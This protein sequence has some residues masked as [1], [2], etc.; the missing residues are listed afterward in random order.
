LLKV[1]CLQGNQE[2]YNA[3]FSV[4]GIT[5]LQFFRHLTQIAV[6]LTLNAKYF[7]IASSLIIVPYL[8]PTQAQYSTVHGLYESLEYTLCKGWVP[9]TVLAIVG[10]TGSAV[11]RLFCGW[12]CP[13]GMVQDFLSYLPFSKTRPDPAITKYLKG[14][15]WAILGV[16]LFCA[17]VVGQR[18][19]DE[20]TETPAVV[21]SGPFSLSVFNVISP[22]STLFAYLPF[23]VAWKSHALVDAG[24]IALLKFAFFIFSILPAVYI[25]RFFCRYLCPL[26]ALLS[27]FGS[28]KFVALTRSKTLSRDT[29]NKALEDVCPMG[30]VATEENIINSWDCIH[31]GKCV[32][33]F[34][35]DLRQTF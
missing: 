29:L 21:H 31:C 16:C 5:A 8:W 25:P 26:G 6:F 35:N 30:V 17:V 23:L 2:K 12:A 9:L 11:G 1:F 15:K 7:G 20:E 24:F 32:S 28:F 13:F 27:P 14:A 22:A 33:E 4:G 19:D 34:P 18:Q 3:S 10:L